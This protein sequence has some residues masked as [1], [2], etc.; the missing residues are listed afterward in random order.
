MK[1]TVI[2]SSRDAVCLPPLQDRLFAVC[3][4]DANELLLFQLYQSAA[5]KNGRNLSI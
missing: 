4:C 5:C 1:G 2:P 3:S